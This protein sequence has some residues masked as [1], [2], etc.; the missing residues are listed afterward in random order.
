[1]IDF[2]I[3]EMPFYPKS[4]YDTAKL[5]AYWIIKNY[6]DAY[7]LYAVDRILFNHESPCRGKKFVTPKIVRAGARI[8]AGLQKNIVSRHP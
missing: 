7:D 5:Y 4:P 6:R 8:K 1:M 2:S 3:E